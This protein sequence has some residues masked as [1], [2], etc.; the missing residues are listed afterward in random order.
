MKNWKQTEWN[1]FDLLLSAE[2]EKAHMAYFTGGADDRQKMR[3]EVRAAYI[4]T[5]TDAQAAVMSVADALAG[6]RSF[7]PAFLNGGTPEPLHTETLAFSITVNYGAVSCAW[8]AEARFEIDGAP[9]RSRAYVKLQ[10]VVNAARAEYE[11]A[12]SM[13]AAQP[14]AGHPSASEEVRVLDAT[15]ITV[16]VKD[17]KARYRV[18]AEPFSKFGVAI[19]PEALTA[20]GLS[21]D[22]IPYQGLDIQRKAHVMMRDGKP[23]KVVRLE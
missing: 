9:A 11:R 6:V 16:E 5:V 8:S 4:R 3:D 20:A 15:R 2:L 21:T 22:A 13:I 19:Y 10:D 23:H 14:P 17:G 12:N 1:E 18:I 7:L